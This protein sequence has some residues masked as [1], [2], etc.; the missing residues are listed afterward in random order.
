[1]ALSMASVASARVAAAAS[2]ASEHFAEP[3]A[4]VEAAQVQSPFPPR[5]V[6]D[7]AA[8]HGLK[9]ELPQENPVGNAFADAKYGGVSARECVNNALQRVPESHGQA[10]PIERPVVVDSG[11]ELYTLQCQNGKYYVGRTTQGVA[12][13]A[14]QHMDRKGGSKWTQLHA[15]VQV[16][17]NIGSSLPAEDKFSEDTLVYRTMEVYG[18][19][20][21]RGGSY[22]QVELSDAQ[23]QE[24]ATKMSSAN[25]RCF[26]CGQ[27]GHF[28]KRCQN[29]QTSHARTP[30]LSHARPPQNSQPAPIPTLGCAGAQEGASRVLGNPAVA[31]AGARKPRTTPQFLPLRARPNI[32]CFRCGAGSHLATHCYAK[33]DISGKPIR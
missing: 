16:L 4:I 32:R 23:R 10:P 14:Q 30:Q 1:M 6:T 5:A 17:P 20:N 19:D 33:R 11:W 24:L 3:P 12:I 27:K 15:P 18:I 21:V 28:A 26:M 8:L 22:C 7:V 25:D 29:A 31:T 2:A 13:R 9:E